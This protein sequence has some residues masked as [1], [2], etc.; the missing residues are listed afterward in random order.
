MT[1]PLVVAFMLLA[2]LEGAHAGGAL[3]GGAYEVDVRLGLPHIDKARKAAIVCVVDGASDGISGLAILSDNNPLADCPVRN[4]RLGADWLT[5][6]IVCGG[7]NAAI[8]SA[9][10]TL[11]ADRFEGR[12][13]MKM[14]G[15]N[16]TMTETQVGRRIGPCKAP[17][18]P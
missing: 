16:M 4:V 15:K 9:T 2:S 13:A 17:G 14:G 18:A 1:R 3:R 5:F 7:G 10:Y 6:D 11:A 8:A 12:I